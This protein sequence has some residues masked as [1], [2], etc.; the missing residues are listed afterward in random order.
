[1]SEESLSE[2]QLKKQGWKLA[3]S[4]GGDHLQRTVD[5]Y[6][7]LGIETYLYKVEPGKCGDCTICFEKGSEALYRIYIKPVKQ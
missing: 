3:T 5:M 7:A 6:R 1:M 2:E 4:T